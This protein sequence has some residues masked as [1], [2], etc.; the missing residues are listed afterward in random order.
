MPGKRFKAEEIVN[1]LRPSPPNAAPRRGPHVHAP[2]GRR[3]AAGG[4]HRRDR[5][6]KSEP[7]SKWETFQNSFGR[8]AKFEYIARG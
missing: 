2:P 1:K 7:L 5:G 4:G 8:D 3:L 6:G